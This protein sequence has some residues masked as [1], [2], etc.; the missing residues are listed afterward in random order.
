MLSKTA[1]NIMKVLI[2]Q[3]DEF[4][5]YERIAGMH[6]KELQDLFP[7]ERVAYE[8]RKYRMNYIVRTLIENG[9]PYTASLFAEELYVS[10]WCLRTRKFIRKKIKGRRKC[11]ITE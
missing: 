3:D 7:K 11:R 6:N 1:S 2:H 10:Y 8:T 4:I 5:T 9:E